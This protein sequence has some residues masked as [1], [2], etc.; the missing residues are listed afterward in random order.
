M[1][2]STSRGTSSSRKP[3][4]SSAIPDDYITPRWSDD[5]LRRTLGFSTLGVLVFGG[6]WLAWRNSWFL[7]PAL[8]CGLSLQVSATM[9]AARSAVDSRDRPS[10]RRPA[11]KRDDILTVLAQFLLPDKPAP[12]TA[13]DTAPAPAEESTRTLPTAMMAPTPYDPTLHRA[14]FRRVVEAE[15]A[16]HPAGLVWPDL[17]AVQGALSTRLRLFERQPATQPLTEREIGADER[18]SG[19]PWHHLQAVDAREYRRGDTLARLSHRA[20][21]P[22]A[23]LELHA[24]IDLETGER[25]ELETELLRALAV[26]FGKIL[27]PPSVLSA[28]QLLRQRLGGAEAIG[29]CDE[30]RLVLRSASTMA[31]AE[32][33][34]AEWRARAR[35]SRDQLGWPAEVMSLVDS[36]IDYWFV[37]RAAAADVEWAEELARLDDT[38]IG[39][40]LAKRDA[41][42]EFQFASALRLVCGGSAASLAA[43]TTPATAELP[44]PMPRTAETV[45]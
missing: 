2:T 34:R 19:Q 18:G 5:D 10:R 8:L 37:Q 24:R 25:E 20:F 1:R 6:A 41:D 11:A 15:F 3:E 4:P 33:L 13:A 12:A 43:S 35:V 27:T 45:A 21:A 23:F 17:A 14:F 40:A 26:G 36:L 29:V 30:A 32:R 42:G 9:I 44:Q 7:W 38:T 31:D 39:A 16:E 22:M 28:A